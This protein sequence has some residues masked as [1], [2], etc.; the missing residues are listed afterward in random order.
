ME[1]AVEKVETPRRAV[2]DTVPAAKVV[3]VTGASSGIGRAVAR[4]LQGRGFTVF[5]TSRVHSGKMERV[6]MLPLDVR[7][8]ESVNTCVRVVLERAGRLDVLINNAGYVLG[9]AIEETALEE[10]R[11]QFETNF[12]GLVRMVKAVLP[13]MRR[14]GGGRIVNISSL[15]GLA[16]VPFLGFYSASKFALEGYSEALLHEV[17]PFNIH[18]SLVE[19]GFI[20]TNLLAASEQSAACSTGAYDPARQAAME[21]VRS[22]LEQA[23]PPEMVAAVVRKIVE[24]SS[25]R[26]R[27]NVGKEA[28]LVVHLRRF[29]PERVALK[30]MKKYFRLDRGD[31]KRVSQPEVEQES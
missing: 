12:F 8:E 29:V 24:S 2:V 9:G 26:L 1:E 28:R 18:V 5:G 23:P 21:S 14:Q 31:C 16:A 4:L 17:M 10:A 22:Y 13:I 25:P 27:Y 20:R 19:P 6:E 7:S 30:I 11:A 15:A 3:L